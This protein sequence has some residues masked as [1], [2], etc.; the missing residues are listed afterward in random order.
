MLQQP[1]TTQERAKSTATT[2]H[3]ALQQQG[4]ITKHSRERESAR[5]RAR[6]REREREGEREGAGRRFKSLKTFKTSHFHD[7]LDN[8]PVSVDISGRTHTEHT[9][10]SLQ[11]NG[12]LSVVITDR[13]QQVSSGEEEYYQLRDPAGFKRR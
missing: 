8:G 10:K 7:S 5:E 2:T 3:S 4:Q 11:D 9:T 12:P 1:T 6:E 13:N